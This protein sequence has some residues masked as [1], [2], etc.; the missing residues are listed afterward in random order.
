MCQTEDCERCDNTPCNCGYEY[1]DLNVNSFAT[2]IADILGRRSFPE[3]N[4]ILA[5]TQRILTY[6]DFE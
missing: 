1:Q 2:F 3:Q 6:R 4:Q 5:E